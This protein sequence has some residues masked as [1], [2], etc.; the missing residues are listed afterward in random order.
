M[1]FFSNVTLAPGI[2]SDE[3]W[4]TTRPFIT[5]C[6]IAVAAD[7]SKMAVVSSFAVLKFISKSSINYKSRS[8]VLQNY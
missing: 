8:V 7:A 4:L 6:D 3:D 2:A 1:S 5:V